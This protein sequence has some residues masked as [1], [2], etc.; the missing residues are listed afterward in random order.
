MTKIQAIEAL[1]TL[2]AVSVFGPGL[3]LV[4]ILVALSVAR[5]FLIPASLRGKFWREVSE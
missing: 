3:Q 1:E 2:V 5:R 4:A